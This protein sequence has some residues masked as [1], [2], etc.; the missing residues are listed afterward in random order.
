MIYVSG[1]VRRMQRGAPL[2][3]WTQ[4]SGGVF[5]AVPSR[6]SP[7]TAVALALS[8]SEAAYATLGEARH[9]AFVYPASFS[10][11]GAGR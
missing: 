10:L 6:V 5:L 8:A 3:V 1:R 4:A 2:G 11:A 7:L 9:G